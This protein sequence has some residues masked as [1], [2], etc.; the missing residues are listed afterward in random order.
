M[1]HII[2]LN[3]V[4]CALNDLHATH[5]AHDIWQTAEYIVKLERILHAIL[6]TDERGQGQPFADAMDEAKR[7]L[8]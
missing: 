7:T 5:M 6:E 8:R 2:I 3:K 1:N 4:G